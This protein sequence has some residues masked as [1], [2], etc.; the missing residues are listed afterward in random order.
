MQFFCRQK[1]CEENRAI[2]KI[3]ANYRFFLAEKA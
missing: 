2:L 1:N 3:A